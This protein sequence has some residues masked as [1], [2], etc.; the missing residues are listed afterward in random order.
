MQSYFET[1]SQLLLQ[2]GV[3]LQKEEI[4]I[5]QIPHEGNLFAKELVKQAYILGAKYVHVEFIDSEIES[6]RHQYSFDDYLDYYP[7]FLAQLLDPSKQERLAIL[8]FRTFLSSTPVDSSKKKRCDTAQK[9]ALL[10]YKQKTKQISSCSAVLP[11]TFWAMHLFPH[12]SESEALSSLWDL[13][14]QVT[15]VYTDN[16]IHFWK[17]KIQ[18]TLYRRD[19][20]NQHRFKTLHFL[21][22][23]TNL[24]VDLPTNHLWIGGGELNDQN[25]L[26]MP[27][28]PTEEIF[29]ANHKYKVSGVLNSSRPL[30]YN[31]QS[32]SNV[33]LTFEEG[34]IINA[35][36]DQ[37]SLLDELLSS[38]DMRYCGEIALV[39]T[40]SLLNTFKKPFFHTL[41]D[42]NTGCHIAL[43]YAYPNSV[44]PSCPYTKESYE[45]NHLNFASN[46]LDLV[47]GTETLS[48]TGYTKDH[49]P[50]PLII[51]GL[52]VI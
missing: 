45:S 2:C 34:K 21:D 36:A 15:G 5:I 23:T 26:S 25:I 35:T 29:S 27:N 52:W 20:L 37:Q 11:T 28:F 51:D 44:S 4:L 17:K 31:Q 9:K 48:V 38:N 7:D 3:N 19:F 49:Q 16:P 32:I 6:L 12:H 10:P 47:F 14:F 30:L 1:Y 50:Y 46:H 8:K 22:S 24:Y 18:K 43:G 39:G 40:D 13:L 33:S 41:L 42:E